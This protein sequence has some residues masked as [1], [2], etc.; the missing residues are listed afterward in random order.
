MAQTLISPSSALQFHEVKASNGSTVGHVIIFDSKT[1]GICAR[2]MVKSLLPY[3]IDGMSDISGYIFFQTQYGSSNE[4]ALHGEGSRINGGQI[5]PSNLINSDVSGASIP[6]QMIDDLSFS[7]SNSGGGG[8]TNP[9]TDNEVSSITPS[10]DD[11][12]IS[13]TDSRR[14]TTVSY[15][16]SNASTD[17][18][19]VTSSN[20]SSIEIGHYSAANGTITIQL[21]AN[22]APATSTITVSMGGRSASFTATSV[23]DS[24]GGSTDEL[25][26]I[27]LN[28]G[29]ATYRISS[30]HVGEGQS[31][32]IPITV[33]PAGWTGNLTATGVSDDGESTDSWITF[34][35]RQDT[36]GGYRLWC[37]PTAAG[38]TNCTVRNDDGTVSATIFILAETA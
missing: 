15:S 24:G 9:P 28:E 17:D 14:S 36:S 10:E 25:R 6:F 35:I 37:Y 5:N 26:S 33:D 4:Y 18:L 3:T 20:S 11:V 27:K 12:S 1:V 23:N 16:P 31:D 21:L 8:E 13:L 38:G 19:N 34:D 30:D 29:Q 2:W 32:W 7:G 22:S